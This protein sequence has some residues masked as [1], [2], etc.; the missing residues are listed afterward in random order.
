MVLNLP[1][2]TLLSR[3]PGRLFSTAVLV[4]TGTIRKKIKLIRERDKVQVVKPNQTKLALNF[5]K[6]EL[7]NNNYVSC[8]TAWIKE[9]NCTNPAFICFPHGFA[10]STPPIHFWCWMGR[11]WEINV[12]EMIAGPLNHLHAQQQEKCCWLMSYSFFFFFLLLI[13]FQNFLSVRKKAR[14]KI[15][16]VSVSILKC[17]RE[18]CSPK[19]RASIL[20]FPE[21]TN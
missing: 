15:L 8:F 2:V 9:L 17:W 7:I 3:S 21:L 13:Q 19:S 14:R 6:A 5:Q 11:W 10:L 20:H 16:A 1:S 18:R 4:S 12:T